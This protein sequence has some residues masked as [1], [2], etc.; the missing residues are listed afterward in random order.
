MKKTSVL[1]VFFCLLCATVVGL[2]Q[3]TTANFTGTWEL[4][5]AKSKMP[6]RAHIGSITMDVSQIDKKIRI[7]TS[8]RRAEPSEGKK[9]SLDRD[10]VGLCQAGREII[11]DVNTVLIYS[12]DSKENTDKWRMPDGMPDPTVVLKA[13]ME[14]DGKLKLS[15]SCT[16]ETPMGLSTSKTNE[17]WEL[18][19]GGKGLNIT[20]DTETPR[21][22]QTSEMYFSN[23]DLGTEEKNKNSSADSVSESFIAL[24][25][26]TSGILNGKA[27]KLVKPDYPAAARANRV[28]GVVNVA[29]KFDEQGDV[30]SAKAVSGHPLL[31]EAAEQAARS[32]KFV[33]VLLN[34]TPVKVIGLVV[35]NLAP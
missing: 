22:T 26:R 32:S 28:T 4:D 1:M 18:L 14:K 2:A 13:S 35:Y 19:D 31:K 3:D 34:G 11:G 9:P 8:F 17:T 25:I 27:V 10:S 30:V 12:L 16:Y 15:S 29:V 21:G 7:E 24:K 20:R 33:P 5:A 23:K 6:E